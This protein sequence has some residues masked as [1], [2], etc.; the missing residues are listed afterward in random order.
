[1]PPPPPPVIVAV[2]LQPPAGADQDLPE[3]APRA[4]LK[5]VPVGS[6]PM[7]VADGDRLRLRVALSD[8][9][10]LRL[11][12]LV[13]LGVAVTEPDARLLLGDLLGVATELEPK[14]LERD[15]VGDTLGD[16]DGGMHA[17]STTAPAAPAAAVAPPTNDTAP[18]TTRSV[19]LTKELPPPP[20]DG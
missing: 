12:L 19:A 7:A 13:A 8:A 15:I 14:L 16:D 18:D 9:D 17:D 6:T 1:M 3:V 10:G 5:P 2:T 4:K 20:P 11:R